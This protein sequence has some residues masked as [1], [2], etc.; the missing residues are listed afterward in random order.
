MKIKS[1]FLIS[2]LNITL[3]SFGQF[4]QDTTKKVNFAAIP[5]V[6]YDP[7]LGL[8]FGI[9]GQVFY[10]LNTNDTISPS[11]FTGVFGMYTSNKTYFGAAFQ[12]LYINEDTW[13]ILAAAGFGNINF[14]YWQDIP[15]IGGQFIGFSTEAIFGVVEVQRKLYNKLYG[16]VSVTYAKASTEFDIPDFF[17]DSLK[18]DER[19]LNNLGYLFNYDVR[20]HQ[21]NPY[22][23]FNVE[24][25]NYFYREW[26]G[27]DDNFNK[28]YL[29]YNHYYKIK[30]ERN[31]I[32][33]RVK[34]AISTGSVPFQGQNVVG[35]DDIRGYT[36]GKYRANQIYAL[37]AEYRWRFYKDFGMVGFFGIASA[38]DKIADI[39][40][41]SILPGIGAGFRYMM[42][43]KERI[44]VGVDVAVG[45]D[46]WGIYFRI[47]EAFGR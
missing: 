9:L 36:S 13:R 15:I 3:L 24:F 47:G 44:N 46:D 22:G 30:N 40:Q 43:S 37:Q 19:M 16:G 5:I 6:N 41:S 4:K 7:S 28:Y 21:L 35:G 42:I 12:K 45:K 11:S 23:G 2:L 26:M 39:P 27:G 20:E 1:L 14:Q 29:T 33:T 10:K 38:V 17:P 18:N 25:K 32:A 31:I 34:T 8:S